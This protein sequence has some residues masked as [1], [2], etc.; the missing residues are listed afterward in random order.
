MN[1][2]LTKKTKQELQDIMR[3]SIE[4]SYVPASIYN[5][6]RLE[7][8][9]RDMNN[10]SNTKVGKQNKQ[11]KKATIE[12]WLCFSWSYLELAKIGC[13]YWIIRLKNPKEFLDKYSEFSSDFVTTRSF[14][15]IIFNIKH[16][17]ELFLKRVS[18]SLDIKTEYIH[19]LLELS[20]NL[21]G[22]DWDKIRIKINKISSTTKSNSQDIKVAKEI[23]QKK[24]HLEEKTDILLKIT[25][26]YYHLIPF[27]N[28]IDDGLVLSDVKNDAFR[29]PE[30]YL[31]VTFDY[32]EFTEKITKDNFD[33]VKKD[34]EE[35]SK[36]YSDIG[37]VLLIYAQN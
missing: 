5:K 25:K 10:K 7:L 6:A 2:D 23:C 32:R 22:V 4:N 15:P 8:E 24:N 28:I 31:S 17:L 9:I 3:N 19:D 18:S 12:E 26:S 30:N 11:T 33:R 27:I 20:K 13:D 1:D 16:S 37:F 34:I 14:L 36:C 35:I 29:Y 21:E